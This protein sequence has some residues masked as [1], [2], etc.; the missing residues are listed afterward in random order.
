MGS[1]VPGLS[2]GE[3][4]RKKREKEGAG[5][6]KK[7]RTITRPFDN[8][9]SLPA[10]GLSLFFHSLPDAV[11]FFRSL[12]ILTSLSLSLFHPVPNIFD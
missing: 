10:P 6:R 2:F 1:F 3:R 12:S 11:L 7:E 9:F 4:E 8:P 5:E